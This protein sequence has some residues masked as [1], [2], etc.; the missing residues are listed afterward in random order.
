M[1][2]LDSAGIDTPMKPN[3]LSSP[4]IHDPSVVCNW[5]ML[6]SPTRGAIMQYI[7]IKSDL[8]QYRYVIGDQDLA[9]YLPRYLA[10]KH[11]EEATTRGANS[12]VWAL[13]VFTERLD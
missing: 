7:V 3:A 5:Q 10:L 8:L 12:A 4:L 11:Q 6:Y 9:A 13:C 2:V 1:I